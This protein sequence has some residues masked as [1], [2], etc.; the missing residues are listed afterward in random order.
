MTIH[1]SARLAWHMDGWNGCICREPKANTYC[2]GQ[3]S[4]PGSMI[5][6]SRD[7]AWE[8]A[9]AGSTCAGLDAAPPCV[10][11]LNA[12]G[13][14][15]LTAFADPPDFFFDDTERRQWTL[16]A[17]TV[18]LWP[19]EEMYNEAVRKGGSYDNEKRR[20]AARSYF[21][22]FE[23]DRS[24]IFYYS[25]YSNPFNEVEARRYV[26]VGISRLQEIGE[27][28]FYH[29]CSQATLEKY[30]G[31]FVWQ[32]NVTSHYPNQ[33]FRIPY[34]L[35]ANKPEILERLLFVP[36][37]PRNFKYATRAIGDD[38]ALNLVERLL[39]TV[40]TVQDV[41]DTSEHW[42]TRLAWLQSLVSE[43]W[44]GRGLFPGMPRVLQ[45]IGF[46]DAIPFFKKSHDGR[47]QREAATAIFDWLEGR[48]K[49]LEGLAVPVDT[50]K[51]VRRQWRLKDES[52]QRL[53]KDI[54]PRFD[55]QVDQIDRILSE[56][57]AAYG[58]TSLIKNVAENPYVLSEEYVGDGPDDTISF[59]KIDH[60]LFPS[61]EFGEDA[62]AEKDD[63]RRLR[64]LIVER[65]RSQSTH[66]FLPAS[67]VIHDVN[68]RLAALPEWKRHQF[69]E[70]YLRADED[71]LAGALVFRDDGGQRFIYLK[72][73]FDDEREIESVL[74]GLAKRKDI[75]FRS[76][77][78]AKHWH[79]WL[80][81]PKSVLA[82]LNPAEYEAAIGGQVAVC[83]Q[84]F[85]R[86][87]SVLSGAAGTGKTTVVR[88][89]L[90]AIE[91]AH[92]NTSFQLLAPTGKAA[93][94]LR[95][96]TGGLEAST[97]HSFLAKRGWLND[98]FT[99]KRNGGQ[100][101][102][103]VTTYIVDEASMLDLDLMAALCR[104][105]NWK[106]VQRLIL[107]G[108]PNQLPPIGRGR[109]F[110]ELV[111]WLA[112]Q[113]AESLA[114][115]NINMRQMEGRLRGA[116]TGILDLA[117]LYL[118]PIGATQ[119]PV[120]A[121]M[122]EQVL[123]KVQEG[124]DIDK[125][126]RVVYWTDGNDL[127]EKL[128]QTMVA[129]IECDTGKS[130]DPKRPFDLWRAAFQGQPHRLQILSPYRGEE[131]GTD[132]LNA[133]V[134]R[135]NRG[136]EI[137]PHRHIDGIAL[138]D[139]IIQVRNRPKSNR[140]YAYDPSTKETPL[141]E[142]FNGELGFVKPHGFD[143]KKWQFPNFRL[144]H[145]QV[146][147]ERREHLFVGYG[148]DLGQTADKKR[149]MPEEKPE[150]NLELAYAIS[151]H[152]AQ[153]SEFDRTYL[154]MP[155]ERI[156][157]LSKELLYTGLTRASRHCTL[158]VQEDISPLLKMFRA[159]ASHLLRINSSLF[160]FKPVPD[161]LQLI[162]LWHE[163][164]KIHRTV[165]DIL[166]RSKSEVIIANLLFD[167]EIPFRYEV[168]LFAPD[169][170]FYLPDFTIRWQGEDYY[171]EHWGRLDLTKYRNHAET[172]R[173]WYERFFPGRLVSTQESGEL[174][175]LAVEVIERH[176]AGGDS[177]S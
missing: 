20:K 37:N 155:K 156:A 160:S 5:L 12:F 113:Q 120:D 169:G 49:E 31:G 110:A 35:Y 143:G 102:D 60:G 9:H 46:A 133:V 121:S 76:P 173:A 7:L 132:R 58:L 34:H 99:F 30:G 85:T 107:V 17:A 93:D 32:R 38:D 40:R 41:G 162:D 147:F 165:A 67:A 154:V 118:R 75:T 10:Y 148:K 52:Q 89:I 144:K 29:N 24:L 145:F 82:T 92:P 66:T 11:S 103:G 54:L 127:S 175:R 142:L 51:R 106:T 159:E 44:R 84:I 45:H 129:D 126:L 131:H 22:Q 88:A 71:D 168:P 111:D 78:T 177:P 68:S 141:T 74:R 4:Y 122:A 96:R 13:S 15:K 69:T 1:L 136:R 33:G 150:D 125:D 172:K 167:R 79:D 124:G 134:Q 77:V 87:L 83:E 59:S 135:H 16:P 100:V 108:D 119:P 140:I 91:K 98:N 80:Y 62:V 28:L 81:D 57:R 53:L 109:V 153:G 43:L 151:V 104:A 130:F 123:A 101:E 3:H 139:K 73:V 2:V 158:L 50:A 14:Q 56:E 166:V 149:W 161:E 18:C 128:L 55:L 171:W 72:A 157:L 70:R 21:D 42:P 48:T 63:W 95:E 164:G 86:P 115:L 152:K 36:D 8:Q 23:R 25:N 116:G 64:A 170:T 47:R 94:R 163:E 90:A 97:I 19:Y 146:V 105:V 65:M 174:S 117:C 39:E 6:E 176:F 61:P 26:L 137:E 138:F 112:E 27:E 114:V